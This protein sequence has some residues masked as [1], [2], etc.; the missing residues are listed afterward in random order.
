MAYQLLQILRIFSIGNFT[1]HKAIA[2]TDYSYDIIMDCRD[3]GGVIN[4]LWDED[5]TF[6]GRRDTSVAPEC[7]YLTDAC[8]APVEGTGMEGTLERECQGKVRCTLEVEQ[9]WVP[10]ICGG[11]SLTY[12]EVTYLCA[13]PGELNFRTF[14][15]LLRL[16]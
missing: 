9:T 11:D 10:A 7:S 5:A 1:V 6:Y 13:V 16:K 8:T 14:L 15:M 2:C 3:H 4:I 12:I